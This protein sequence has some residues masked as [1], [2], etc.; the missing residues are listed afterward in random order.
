MTSI[1]Y[2]RNEGRKPEDIYALIAGRMGLPAAR[3]YFGNSPRLLLNTPCPEMN[4]CNS[5][6]FFENT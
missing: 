1:L 5:D 2:L 6:Y 4:K 3:H